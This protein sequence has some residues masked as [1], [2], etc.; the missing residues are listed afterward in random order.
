MRDLE[1]AFALQDAVVKIRQALSAANERTGVARE[2]AEYD[3]LSKR[4]ALLVSL[5]EAQGPGFVPMGELQHVN[6]PPRSEDWRDRGQPKIAVAM[7]DGEH[8]AALKRR[9]DETNAAMYAKAD[10]LAELNKAKLAIELPEDIARVA[11]L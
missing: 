4:A 10:M 3:A 1:R 8:G 9:A 2:L 7:I 6:T 11:G 5:L